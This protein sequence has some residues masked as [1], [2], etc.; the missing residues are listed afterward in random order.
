MDICHDLSNYNKTH[1]KGDREDASVF[2]GWQQPPP[3]LGLWKWGGAGLG[4]DFYF[5]E[6]APRSTPTPYIQSQDPGPC[7]C[8]LSTPKGFPSN[9]ALPPP[10]HLYRKGLLSKCDILPDGLTF[11]HRAKVSVRPEPE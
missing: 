8:P 3:R 1:Q 2:T 5:K 6:Q 9:P 11:S 4:A 10:P 7:P